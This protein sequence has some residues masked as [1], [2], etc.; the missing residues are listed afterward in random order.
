MLLSTHE[1][2]FIYSFEDKKAIKLAY[3]YMKLIKI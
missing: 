3:E 2:S 1:Q